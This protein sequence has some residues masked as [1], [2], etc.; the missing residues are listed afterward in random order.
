M[1][2]SSALTEIILV[3]I[4]VS[5]GKLSHEDAVPRMIHIA[6]KTK[7]RRSNDR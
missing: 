4:K 6:M 1:E 3:G 2:L 7:R 5:T